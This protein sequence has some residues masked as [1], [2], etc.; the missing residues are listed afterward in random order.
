[1]SYKHIAIIYKVSTYA[2]IIHVS[3]NEVFIKSASFQNSVFIYSVKVCCQ[4]LPKLFS[5][6]RH[7]FVL[8]YKQ[9]N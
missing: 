9:K 8:I 2:K 6:G 7:L 5:F 1:M 3:D 4:A